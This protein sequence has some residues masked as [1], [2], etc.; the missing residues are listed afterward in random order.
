[1]RE[2]EEVGTAAPVAVN[3]DV[4]D[5]TDAPEVAVPDVAVTDRAVELA[6]T[7]VTGVPE[8][9]VTDVTGVAET[10]VTDVTS[11]AETAVSDV[12][13]AA[14][15][16]VTDVAGVTATDVTVA[17]DAIERPWW[18]DAVVYQVY[19]RS[20]ADANGDGIGDISGVRARLPYLAALGVD[21]LWFNPWYPSPLADAG[22]DISDY[23]SI[24]PAFGTIWE[25]EQLIAE[26]RTLGIR[27]IVDIVPNH[28]SIEHPWFQEALASPPGSPARERFWLRP[29]TGTAGELPPN[30]WQSIFGGQAW[31]RVADGEWYLHLFA[32]EQPDLNWEDPEVW[33]EH[34]DIL[35]F[36]FERGV[37]GVRI[38]SAALLVKDPGLPEEVPNPGPGEHP[39]TDR[40]ELHY[41]YRRWRT[42]ADSYD[43]PRLLVGEVWLPDAERFARYL[44]PDEL[45]TAFNFDFLACPWEPGPMLA[46]IKSALAAHAPVDAPATWV[47]SNHDVTRPVTR[48]GR[49]DTRF[50]FEAKREGTPT[51][52]VR[53]A[54]R[55]RAAA[56]LAMALPGSMYIYQGD[57]LG[58]PEAENIP[59]DRRQD[60]MW[61]RSGGVDPGRDGCRVPIPWS[62][63]KPPYGFSPNDEAPLWL[64]QPDDWA[65]LS[66]EA[67]T[68]DPASM[69]SLYR[70]GLRIRRDAPWGVDPEL[71]WLDYGDDVIAF[72]RGERFICIVNFGPQPIELPVEADVLVGSAELVG[73]V[74]PQDTSVWLIQTLDRASFDPESIRT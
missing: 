14:E 73:N 4:V 31:T 23:R 30:G 37:A 11:V 29:G 40:D 51:D 1:M 8:T 69:L 26:A 57:E 66:V 5:V 19:I 54:R 48:Y 25:A 22:Y 33:A 21:A 63:A 52:L 53:G 72:A 28:V 58:L 64:D 56:L 74:V 7:D 60:P 34:E 43:E 47:L 67:Q 18:R 16:A 17:D 36:W 10:A 20:F 71:R 6:A 45:H 27:T 24:D 65:P 13:G 41:I 44:R 46:S 61:R 62:G 15:A 9:G 55:A 32:P 59:T 35:R 68:D 49:V 38:D 70:T 50:A 3:G 39:F 2:T 12:T 42:I